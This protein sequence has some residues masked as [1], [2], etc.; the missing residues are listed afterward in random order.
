[1]TDS[2]ILDVAVRISKALLW[3]FTTQ[4]GLQCLGAAILFTLLV[5]LFKSLKERSLLLAATGKKMGIGN[6]FSV[7]V[8]EIVSI[9]VMAAANIPI[10][11][12]TAAILS[13]VLALSGTVAK[14]DEFLTLQQKIREYSL[15]LKNLERRHKVARVECTEQ[16]GGKTTLSIEYFDQKGRPVKGGGEAI[17]IQGTDIFI[18]ALVINFAYSGIESG[19]KRNLAIPYRV[20]SEKVAQANGLPL[21]IATSHGI[22]PFMEREEHQVFGLEKTVFES[23]LTELMKLATD[24]ERARKAGLVRSLHGNAVHKVMQKGDS[25]YIWVEQS[26]GL[27]IKDES[28]F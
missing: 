19:E 2:P 28:R 6:A 16:V 4:T 20:F 3:L 8:Q 1:M 9:G 25:F 27:T 23:R 17:E 7:M 11:I 12:A 22:P 26:G 10:L 18:D 13:V 5:R 15:V 24:A 14:L 21:K